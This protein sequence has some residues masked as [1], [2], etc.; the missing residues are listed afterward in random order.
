MNAKKNVLALVVLI[1]VMIQVALPTPAYAAG[2]IGSGTPT[3]CD[4]TALDTALGGGGPINFDCGGGPVIIAITSTKI[5]SS[6]TQLDGG[7]L[8]TLSGGGGVRLFT[9][10]SPANS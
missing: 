10:D 8:I 4:E 9:V 6:N 3:S 1:A 2:T 5:I 7:G